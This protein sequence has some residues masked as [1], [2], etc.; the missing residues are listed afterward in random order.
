M[1]AVLPRFLKSTYR[2]DPLIS[3]LITV[4][5]VDALIGGLDDSWSLFAFGLGTAGIT[6]ALK[7]W[8]IQQRRSIPEEPVVQHYLPS[9]SSSPTLPMLTVTKKKPP[10]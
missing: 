8:R 9:R 10:Y 2:K 5:V 1:N 3:V 6:L 7:L 4:G